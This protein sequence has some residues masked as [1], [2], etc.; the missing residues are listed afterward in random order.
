MTKGIFSSVCL[1]FFISQ[2]ILYLSSSVNNNKYCGSWNN[3]GFIEDN[4]KE[5]IYHIYQPLR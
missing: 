3:L 4:L 2:H 1:F 5:T